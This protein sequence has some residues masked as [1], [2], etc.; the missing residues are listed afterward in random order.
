MICSDCLDIVAPTAL[1]HSI[2][3]ITG[4]VDLLECH[5]AGDWPP[6]D[7]HCANILILYLTPIDEISQTE[8]C[9]ATNAIAL[10]NSMSSYVGA[11]GVGKR[12]QGSHMASSL[13]AAT[14]IALLL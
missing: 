7:A 12:H 5:A 13:V 4:L 8:S 3:T 10:A 6:G 1:R 11:M 2:A 14:S 9:V